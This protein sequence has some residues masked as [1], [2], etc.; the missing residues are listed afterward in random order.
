MHTEIVEQK[1]YKTV[2]LT[3]SKKSFNDIFNYGKTTKLSKA[4]VKAYISNYLKS[5]TFDDNIVHITYITDNGPVDM[6]H[7][8]TI[9]K[10][11]TRANLDILLADPKSNKHVASGEYNNSLENRA[12]YGVV[13]TIINKIK[14]YK[15]V[16]NRRR[17]VF[18][19]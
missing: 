1:N 13:I 8:V 7:N 18:N 5:A 17:M 19:L 4:T 14:V 2:Y 12:L 16:V 9:E 6:T 10:T 11:V 15:P 3:E